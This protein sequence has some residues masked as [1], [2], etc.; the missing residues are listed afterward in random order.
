MHFEER[1]YFGKNASDPCVGGG[2]EL[3]FRVAENWLIV[4]EVT[5]CKHRNAPNFSGEFAHLCHWT[6]SGTA[7]YRGD[8]IRQLACCSRRK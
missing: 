7:G 6:S 1:T 2:G 8:G 3:G 4:G 5:G